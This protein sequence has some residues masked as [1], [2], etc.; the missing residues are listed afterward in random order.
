MLQLPLGPKRALGTSCF[1]LAVRLSKL[2]LSLHGFGLW[3]ALA[4]FAGAP[5]T[6]LFWEI[7][8]EDPEAEPQVL[9][10][11]ALKGLCAAEGAGHR[12]KIHGLASGAGERKN[13]AKEP[14]GAAR[15][16]IRNGLTVPV[17]QALSRSVAA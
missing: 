15:T 8:H 13:P 5:R 17:D 6:N 7:T 10:A 12:L 1:Q 9:R 14:W 4:A 11:L 2:H 3:R 16:W